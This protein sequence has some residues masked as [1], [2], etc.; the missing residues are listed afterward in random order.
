M[1]VDQ[2]YLISV[3]DLRV[4]CKELTSGKFTYEVIQ[5]GSDGMDDDVDVRFTNGDEVNA[6]VFRFPIVA[7][8]HFLVNQSEH[9]LIAGLH[10]YLHSQIVR[11]LYLVGEELKW[12]G[13]ED[14]QKF[15][16]PLDALLYKKMG[17]NP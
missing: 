8:L 13:V 15:W 2:A 9:G 7:N 4:V 6:L 10:V 1:D 11:G 14:W 3:A 5:V 16:A 12:D 17:L